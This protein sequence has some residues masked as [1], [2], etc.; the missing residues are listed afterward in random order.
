MHSI[1]IEPAKPKLELQEE[2]AQTVASTNLDHSQGKPWCI[3]PIV[4]AFYF[5]SLLINKLDCALIS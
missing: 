4:L 1:E 2:L 3:P 5:E